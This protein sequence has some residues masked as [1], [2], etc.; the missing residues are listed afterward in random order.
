MNLSPGMQYLSNLID[1][2]NYPIMNEWIGL[3]STLIASFNNRFLCS[4]CLNLYPSQPERLEKERVIKGCYNQYD[5]PRHHQ[6][7]IKY[8]TCIG[9][10]YSESASHWIEYLPKYEL[11]VMPFDGSYF[12]QPAKAIQVMRIVHSYKIKWELDRAEKNAMKQSMRI[13][14]GR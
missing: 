4:T 1:L 12:D 6:D 7:D 10:F 9:N 5:E 3:K 2:L 11:G 8:Y 14:R 13:K